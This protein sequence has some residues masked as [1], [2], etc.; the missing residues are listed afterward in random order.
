MEDDI[1]LIFGAAWATLQG[2]DALFGETEGTNLPEPNEHGVSDT[3]LR[4]RAFLPFEQR[5]RERLRSFKGPAFALN[6]R[7]SCLRPSINASIT[8]YLFYSGNPY[9]FIAGEISGEETFADAALDQDYTACY[10]FYSTPMC[11]QRS[12]NCSVPASDPGELDGGNAWPAALCRLPVLGIEGEDDIGVWRVP[13]ENPWAPTSIPFLVF[14]T[15]VMRKHMV[16]FVDTATPLKNPSSFGEWASYQMFDDVFM[17]ITMCF[18]HLNTTVAEVVMER[19]SDLVEPQFK[20]S[21]IINATNVDTLMDFWGAGPAPQG[22]SE[23]GILTIKEYQYPMDPTKLDRNISSAD[24]D[25]S[26][27]QWASWHGPASALW[28]WGVD[29]DSINMCSNCQIK[30]H[31]APKDG[32]AVFLHVV[33]VSGRA[34]L[35][36]EAFV[37]KL[38]QTFYYLMQP[39]FD[40][41]ADI[42]TVSTTRARVPRSWDGLI[43]VL[44][45]IAGD[46]VCVW[47]VVLIYIPNIRYAR[48]GNCWHAVSQLMS[49]QTQP[50]LDQSRELK[51]NEVRRMIKG[52][53][54]LVTI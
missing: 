50:V 45:L 52:N 24:D 33:N 9:G 15:N 30:G 13:Y 22:V 21:P 26:F 11:L 31:S 25:V 5:E 29:S 4:R 27:G 49:E 2:K 23:R 51:D 16:E 12:F 6:T 37:A 8:S 43:A 19:E 10:T 34:A 38:A 42:E 20:W 47:I 32:Q 54:P 35:A 17:N 40:V 46:F 1:G 7:V 28:A 39:M 36:L 41:V 3:G 53:N 48:Q 44:A 14:T 18:A